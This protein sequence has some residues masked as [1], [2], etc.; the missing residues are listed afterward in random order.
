[1]TALQIQLLYLQP[2]IPCG[3]DTNVHHDIALGAHDTFFRLSL[4]LPA[5]RRA[6]HG[7][8]FMTSQKRLPLDQRYA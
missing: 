3:F 5:A 2:T 1:V 7:H 4:T 6:T 8:Y